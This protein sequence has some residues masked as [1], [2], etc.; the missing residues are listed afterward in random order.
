MHD[1]GSYSHGPCTPA[2]PGCP[3]QLC[4][5]TQ[6]IEWHGKDQLLLT[7]VWDPHSGC[8]Y[9]CMRSCGDL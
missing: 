9:T 6:Q 2:A 8:C 7:D 4:S 5:Q 3:S 1:E